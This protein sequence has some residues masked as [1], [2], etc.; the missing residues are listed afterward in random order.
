MS[1]SVS[2][3]QVV[4]EGPDLDIYAAMELRNIFVSLLETGTTDVILNINKVS[5]LSTPAVQGIISASKSFDNFRIEKD[6][7]QLS[8]LEEFRSLG[9]DL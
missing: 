9:I 4:V 3:N 6:S 1:I 8:L 5:T 7:L 2:E